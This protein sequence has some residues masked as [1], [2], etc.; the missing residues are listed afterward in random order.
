MGGGGEWINLH[1]VPAAEYKCSG[2]DAEG[3]VCSMVMQGQPCNKPLC[4][5][6]C[7]CVHLCVCARVCVWG[8]IV[9]PFDVH[10]APHH[11]IYT[12]LVLLY[13]LRTDADRRVFQLQKAPKRHGAGLSKAQTKGKKVCVCVC[14]CVCV[15]VCVRAC[16]CCRI[17]I[18]CPS[19]LTTQLESSDWRKRTTTRRLNS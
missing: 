7:V 4:V 19:L 6:V 13:T 18:L 12:V 8:L 10:C 16:V 11:V 1:I 15:C 14:L 3:P 17:L 5:C 2:C 9:E